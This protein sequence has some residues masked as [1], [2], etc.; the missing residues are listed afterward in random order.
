MKTLLLLLCLLPLQA[1]AN[2]PYPRA[3]T[4]F[5]A[6]VARISTGHRAIIGSSWGYHFDF[7]PDKA[8]GFF[9]QAG[10]SSAKDGDHTFKQNSFATGLQFHLLSVL[11]I[12]LGVA[13]TVLE[14]DKARANEMGPLAA[15]TVTYPL[16]VFKLG[17]NATF[18]NTSSMHS[19]ALRCMLLIVF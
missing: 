13:T 8:I 16:G 6:G 5:E 3:A 15:V 4:G 1:N 18:I 17:T 12:R 7:E 10:S 14:I 9:G 11:D 2:I 19:S